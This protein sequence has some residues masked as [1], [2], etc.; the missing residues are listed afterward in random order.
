MK[1]KLY[2]GTDL[3]DFDEAF[4]V[5]FSIGDIRNDQFGNNNKSYTL[6]LPLTK[7]NKKLLKY[8][9][10]ADVTS[11]PED[12]GRLYL[13]ELL[14]IS[15]VVKV[16]NVDDN[17]AK[18]IIES[19]TWIEELKDRKMTELDLSSH[20]HTFNPTNI[21]ASWSASYPA[22]RYPMIY[23]GGLISG[24]NGGSANWLTGDF[25]PMISIVTL[26]NKILEP[27]TI[28]SS[29]L[30]ESFIKD[31]F[32][33][34]NQKVADEEFIQ[35]KALQAQVNLSTDNYDT[36]SS[37]TNIMVEILKDIQFSNEIT[38]EG[39]DWITDTYTVPETGTYRFKTSITMVN[40]AYE[41][42]N[43]TINQ[44]EFTIDINKN[45][46]SQASFDAGV[47]SST[48]L[49]DDVT[50][51]LDTGYIYCEAGD[52]ITV[53]IYATVSVTVNSGTQTIT[54]YTV[55][56]Y[57]FVENVWGMANRFLGSGYTISFE[58]MLPDITQVD[59][60]SIIKK[61]F[62]LKFWM[63][64]SKQNL[65][66][67]PWDDFVSSTV[68]DLTDYVDNTDFPVDI[69]SKEFNKTI[70]MRFTGDDKDKSFE[71]YLNVNT[72]LP[73]Q[74]E[75]SLTS[76][77]AKQDITYKD[78]EFATILTG[79]N[80]TL[81]D[82]SIDIPIIWKE[83]PVSPYTIF[84]RLADFKTRI[85]EWKGLTGGLSWY[86]ESSSKSTYPK[87][88]ALDF[89]D[90]YNSYWIK[91]YHYVDKGKI[92]TVKIK[93]TPQFLNQFFTVV[94]TAANEGF[95]PTYKITIKGIENY[96]F[97]QSMTTDGDIAELELVLKQ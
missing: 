12:T 77:F 44:E 84:E 88:E 91:H 29:W 30:A 17:H 5:V 72:E 95:R 49:I 11:E 36:G 75:I 14:I 47:Y 76:N 87:I 71:E 40:T 94:D 63:D 60:L 67:E 46:S 74:K 39:E 78:C 42:P 90:I 22:Y 83:V 54:I 43:L 57:S 35:N 41:N 64:K 53:A 26:I 2:I 21:V 31:L 34:C 65:Y 81:Q 61:I 52:L 4:N 20:D 23:F 32:I 13:G 51:E 96:F 48:E 69:I 89:S 8:I 56:I 62:N 10:Q 80:Y 38:D 16:L 92:Y 58:E 15:G 55:P 70:I 18:I 93:L 27:Y 82:Y 85:V 45:G 9:N 7:T 68:I 86:F 24:E 6:N 66:I 1:T 33:L 37:S 97:L 73:G 28:V 19:D 79:K 59:F 50:V 25:I 3:A